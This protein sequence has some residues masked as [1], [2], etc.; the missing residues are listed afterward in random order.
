M[1]RREGPP[2][3][4]IDMVTRV[5]RNAAPEVGNPVGLART[6]VANLEDNA[7][8]TLAYALTALGTPGEL[9]DLRKALVPT[10]GK[11]ATDSITGDVFRAAS[12]ALRS[13][14]ERP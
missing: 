2:A 3:G 1:V 13:M 4:L 7:T 11:L 10:A 14:G 12:D 6:V 8:D 5:I 9:R